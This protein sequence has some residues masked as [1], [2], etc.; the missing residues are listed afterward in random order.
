MVRCVWE[1][2]ADLLFFAATEDAERRGPRYRKTLE[3]IIVAI[4]AL[5]VVGFA[6]AAVMLLL[7]R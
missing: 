4:C 7:G 5:A 3:R 6:V 1:R 2:L